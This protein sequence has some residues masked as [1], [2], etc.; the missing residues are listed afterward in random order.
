[1]QA[2]ELLETPR[3]RQLPGPEKCETRVDKSF[4]AARPRRAAE[5]RMDSAKSSPQALKRGHIFNGLVARVT[6]V[7]FPKP[8]R[9]RVFPQPA[10]TTVL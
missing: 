7:P 2:C 10:S 1:M 4:R 5:K 6:L 8:I 3:C 9:I